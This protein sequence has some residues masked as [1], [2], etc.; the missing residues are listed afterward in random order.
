M[1]HERG[2]VLSCSALTTPATQSVCSHTYPHTVQ[3]QVVQ[4]V[5]LPGQ[6][7]TKQNITSFPGTFSCIS[8]EKGGT[9][10]LKWKTVRLTVNPRLPESL[11]V[12]L[13]LRWLFMTPDAR[14][15]GGISAAG[16][17]F[18]H[19]NRLWLHNS[20]DVRLCYAAERLQSNGGTSTLTQFVKQTLG[21]IWG[22]SMWSRVRDERW[23]NVCIHLSNAV[24]SWFSKLSRTDSFGETKEAL[25]K[26]PMEDWR[27]LWLLFTYRCIGE[28]A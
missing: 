2:T 3:T 17:W 11:A 1:R 20:G 9:L 23:D 19:H 21:L 8:F 15:E 18:I 10:P 25:T 27:W 13:W 26:L 4:F 24:I 5:H 6:A 14:L 7:E 28:F 16:S 22:E 12:A